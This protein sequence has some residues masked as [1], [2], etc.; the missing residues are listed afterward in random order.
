MTASIR[1]TLH[2]TGMDCADCARTIE[3]GVARLPGVEASS[4]NFT[5]AVLHVSG[6]IEPGEVVGRVRELGYDALTE[7]EISAS[8]RTAAVADQPNFLQYIWGR[9]DTRLALLAVLL[10]LPGLLFH[11]L[12]PWLGIHHP[13]L[14][15]SSALA[16]A[17]AG[18]PI[19]ASGWRAFR[20]G[21]QV[22][23]NALMTIAA[24]GAVFIGAYTEAGV[25]MVLFAVGEALEGFT[26]ER[27]RNSIQSLLSTVPARATLLTYHDEH[28]HE[29]DVL[30]E[31][32]Q[33]GDLILVRPG[34]QIPMDGTVASGASAVNQAPITGESSPVS[35]TTGD[36][37]FAGT[38]NGEGSLEITVTHPASENTI[39][40]M[41]RLVEQA[42][43]ERAPVQRFVDRFAAVYTP[44]VVA[45]A[46]GVAVIPPLFFGGTLLG[47]ESGWLYRGLAL[48]VVACPC[49]LVI[50]TPVSIISAISSAARSGIL[51][52]GGAHLE[53]LS[54]VR[55]IA[56]DKTGTLT[57]GRPA[58]VRI[59]AA[60]CTNGAV[61]CDPCRDLLALASSLEQRSEHP[62]A[63]AVV[64]E[65]RHQG[66]GFDYPAAESV[67]A[68]AGRGLAGS[69][70]G[71]RVT[72][73]S[74]GWFDEHIA[75]D[76]H[77]AEVATADR[78]GLTTMLVSRE[79]EYLGYISVSDTVRT[80]SREA[81]QALQRLDLKTVMLTG[82]N[83]A[84]AAQVAREAG[85]SE[86]RAN[87]L[88]EEKVAHI[89]SLRAVYP[90]V[91]M[92]GDGINDTPALAAA[93]IGI[94][95]GT[96]NGATTQAMETAD[97]TLLG[98]D[99]SRLPFAVRLAR[100]TMRIIRANVALSIGIKLAFLVL[101]LVG[102]GSM[103]LAVLAD[104]GTS[105]L[106]TLNGMRLLKGNARG[107]A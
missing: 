37:V 58:V 34:Q 50:S 53:T 41:V 24:V 62:L 82:D 88:P 67:S 2:I 21:G 14:D 56:F 87:C 73:G 60:D 44:V 80:S 59:R 64:H 91:A 103:W 5:M 31:D 99:L 102:L 10:V 26:S 40:R 68:L 15:L 36:P 3:R 49:A 46:A 89:R 98:G 54:R 20:V 55:A 19:A 86:Y 8:T 16:M 29:K 66:V 81:L 75:H 42:Q 77:C 100:R 101:V 18:Y 72:I 61:I 93:S 94:A 52:K 45:I 65:A 25:V 96:E 106:V 7:Q 79:S 84:T 71:K 1:F 22:T 4:L 38:V 13:L 63:V 12:L 47:G 23:I 76:R 85:V 9:T 43:A 27:A 57:E 28:T 95:V 6:E 90:A 107:E 97:V 69:I 32:L 104:M 70:G 78:E 83:E 51:F 74:H 39:A 30:V 48:L 35:K 92:V 17:L 105:L 33:V 11:E